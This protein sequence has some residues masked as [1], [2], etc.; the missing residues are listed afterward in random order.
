MLKIILAGS[1]AAAF[2]FIG[3]SEA[4]PEWRH[5]PPYKPFA[6]RP[7]P[8]APLF[9]GGPLWLHVYDTTTSEPAAG[10]LSASVV[11][12]AT[13]PQAAP[14]VITDEPA[15]V[16]AAPAVQ[17]STEILPAT[18]VTVPVAAETSVAAVA[19]A[20]PAPAVVATASEPPAPTPVTT[21]E[22]PTPTATVAAAETAAP[23]AAVQPAPTTTAE[24]APAVVA[25]P[26]VPGG[27]DQSQILLGI[28]LSAI[29]LGA[30]FLG[31]RT[32]KRA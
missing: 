2:A 27:A 13:P 32:T 8:V 18:E 29:V 30:I 26:A 21:V 17:T 11:E 10:D 19:D 25:A 28:V 5:Y 12:T 14:V 31:R 20:E 16:D 4:K 22:A 1:L 23:T 24:P 15:M 9:V 6:T 3:T 7:A